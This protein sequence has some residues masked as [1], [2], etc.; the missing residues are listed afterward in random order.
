MG[1]QGAT[2]LEAFTVTNGLLKGVAGVG[3]EE[4]HHNPKIPSFNSSYDS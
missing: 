3:V 2:T 4:E 1:D